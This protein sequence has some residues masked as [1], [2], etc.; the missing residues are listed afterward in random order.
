MPVN[1]LKNGGTAIGTMLRI[2]RTPAAALIAK[3]TG[4][5]FIML[6]MEHGAYSFET[7]GDV[8]AASRAAGVGAFVRVPELSRDTVSRALDCGAQGVMVP[9]IESVEQAETFVSW[10]KYPPP[11]GPRPRIIW[12]THRLRRFR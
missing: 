11:R 4:L 9:M 3:K 7:V 5:D 8:F 12:R 6:D 10:A 1:N 2:V